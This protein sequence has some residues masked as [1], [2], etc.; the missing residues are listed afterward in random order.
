[1]IFLFYHFLGNC[2]CINK[3]NGF[4]VGGTTNHC[5]QGSLCNADCINISI[6]D[7]DPIKYKKIVY[8]YDKN[9]NKWNVSSIGK[10]SINPINKNIKIILE[11]LR[12]LYI[13]LIGVEKVNGLIFDYVI[14]LGVNNDN[15]MHYTFYDESD[16]YY[17]LW[18][19][20]YHVHDLKYNSKRPKLKYLI[21]N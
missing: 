16:D 2:G 19:D 15:S 18:T 12:K 14:H 20:L 17:N 3:I 4:S 6:L 11:K 8:E 21:K 9:Y 13:E 10:I 7:L 5:C 1:M